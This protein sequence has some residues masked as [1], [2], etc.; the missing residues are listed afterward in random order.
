M[1]Q[2]DKNGLEVKGESPEELPLLEG[3]IP[4]DEIL[5]MAIQLEQSVT[6][7]ITVGAA[8]AL[9]YSAHSN[10]NFNLCVPQVMNVPW[11]AQGITMNNCNVTI[12]YSK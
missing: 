3:E 9:P 5:E 10:N 7:S 4:D 2:N 12:N 8:P 1:F 11:P 6:E